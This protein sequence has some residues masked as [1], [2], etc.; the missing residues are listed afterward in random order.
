MNGSHARSIG[1]SGLS[2]PPAREPLVLASASPQRR[3]ILTQL[4]VAHEVRPSDVEELSTGDPEHVALA[5]ALRKAGAIAER[6][7]PGRLVLGVDT[8][9]TLDGALF[10]KPRDAEH[11]AQTLGRLQGR[12]HQV[13][14]GLALL[15]VGERVVTTHVSFRALSPEQVV[16]YVRHGEWRGRA[17]GY[18][19]QERGAGLVERIDGDY[20][21]VVGLPVTALLDLAPALL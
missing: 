13:V 12:T 5:N 17:G 2:G 18:A 9:V 10:G 8:V 15:P 7:A 20:F 21:N 14:S 19:I 6:E 11:A 1:G 4:G 3:A 16:R